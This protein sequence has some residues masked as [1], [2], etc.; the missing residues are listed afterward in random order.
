MKNRNKN[1][2]TQINQISST[3]IS[4]KFDINTEK[5]FSKQNTTNIF[6]ISKSKNS[7]TNINTPKN[8]FYKEKKNNRIDKKQK[9][10]KKE[11]LNIE[12]QDRDTIK[13]DL[14]SHS[15]NKNIIEDLELNNANFKQSK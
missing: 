4:S 14:Y 7:F 9:I 15:F 1:I 2:L 6:E 8:N 11:K 12:E 13:L 3:E 5:I 10:N